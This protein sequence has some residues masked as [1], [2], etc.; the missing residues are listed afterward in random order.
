[1]H[2][3][4]IENDAALKRRP[5]ALFSE[6]FPAVQAGSEVL[7]DQEIVRLID[8]GTLGKY[9]VQRRG[10][11]QAGP[12]FLITLYGATCSKIELLGS[13]KLGWQDY[14]V[15]MKRAITREI[16]YWLNLGEP[17]PRGEERAVEVTVRDTDF[18]AT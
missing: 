14:V 18:A 2:V 9:R 10:S 15:A 8:T 11:G 3:T 17:L 4:T 12:V 5:D 13:R 7:R 16:G 6:P 1:M